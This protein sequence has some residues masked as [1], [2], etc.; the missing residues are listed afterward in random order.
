MSI[1]RRRVVRRRRVGRR[2]RVLGREQEPLG[3][4]VPGRTVDRGNGLAIGVE[5]GQQR[6]PVLGVR[7]EVDAGDLAGPAGASLM[8]LEEEVGAVVVVCVGALQA[9]LED[10]VGVLVRLRLVR[11]RRRAGRGR[12]HL[13]LAGR[14][15]DVVVVAV[16]RRECRGVL[17]L[18]RP[19]CHRDLP[20][21]WRQLA[22]RRVAVRL[23]VCRRHV[24]QVDAQRRRRPIRGEDRSDTHRPTHQQREKPLPSNHLLLL[25]SLPRR[26]FRQR[27]GRR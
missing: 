19:L 3:P 16:V 2:A 26:R 25:S 6:H 10:Q 1:D 9:V 5:G 22:G 27:L 12:Q 23:R 8:T 13:R 4:R 20:Q 18:R 11:L 24:G 7:V 15:E 14:V 17:E 21:L